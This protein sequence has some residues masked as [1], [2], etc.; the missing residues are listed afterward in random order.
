[1]K[2]IFKKTVALALILSV[3]AVIFASCAE[4]VY[5]YEYD[6]EFNPYPYADLG[7]FM[8]L[9]DYKNLTMSRTALDEIMQAEI[10]NFCDSAGITFE[11]TDGCEKGDTVSVFYVM[12][13]DGQSVEELSYRKYD[14]YSIPASVYLG[15]EQLPFENELVGM[16]SGDRK[17]CDITLDESY[18]YASYRG[19]TVTFDIELS[20]VIRAPELT[21]EICKQ[22]AGYETKDE[23]LTELEKN[24]I[25]DFQWQVLMDKC[26]LKGVPNTE[27]TQYY[28]QF[29]G[30]V[31]SLAEENGLTLEEFISK[32]GGYYSSY[33]LWHGMTTL[34]LR[35]VADDYARSNV[36]ND[37]LVYSIM[38]AENMKLS[39]EEWDGAVAEFEKEMGLTYAQIVLR[40]SETEAIISV[41]MIRIADVIVSNV[42]VTND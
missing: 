27:Y 38:R 7:V 9:P 28:Q 37:L 19:K 41:I 30:M 4:Q 3:C 33:G 39:G 25:F 17:V 26:E 29:Y 40:T 13:V 1:M 18:P 23:F 14:E 6:G 15:S 16:K 12:Y 22:Y 8:T 11:A 42:T 35:G 20:E 24:C 10:F 32:K 31:Q 5:D 21:D 34:D 2:K 36:V